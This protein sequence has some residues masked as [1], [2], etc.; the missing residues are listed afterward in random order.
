MFT[1]EN[2]MDI[3]DVPP[4]LSNLTYI[5]EQLIAQTHPVISVY[6]LKYGQMG[7]KGNVI[8]FPQ[9]VTTF[10]TQL[11][12]TIDNISRFVIVRKEGT[13]GYTDFFVNRRR[14]KLALEWLK[15]NNIW[16]GNIVISLRNLYDLPKNGD[17]LQ[18]I[19][20]SQQRR[21][22]RH[23]LNQTP[24]PRP[25]QQVTQEVQLNEENELNEEDI[26][27]TSGAPN[28]AIRNN[29]ELINLA[30]N[31]ND[32]QEHHAIINWPQVGPQPINEFTSSGYIA[33]AFPT[34]FPYGR[35]DLRNLP[36]MSISANKYFKHLM[37]YKDGRF[38]KHPRFRFFALNSFMRW[39][40][41]KNGTICISRN[42]QMNRI[43]SIR[44]LKDKLKDHPNLY[45]NILAFNSNLRSTSAYWYVR[46]REL[47]DLV[48]QIGPPTTFITLMRLIYI[49]LAL[50]S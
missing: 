3:G 1:P 24:T 18:M 23:S 44:E 34:L 47:I 21:T 28:I 30:L 25:Q 33:R 2:Q 22:Q 41:L 7:Y 36:I 50:Q 37:K 48:E 31:M 45:K 8:N 46:S 13:V 15:E 5:E 4:Q 20:D 42:E 16:Y 6:R 35:G 40:A 29:R 10:A 17:V 14:V 19:E 27:Y 11:P 9:D 43:H 49:G 26:I 38:A 12:H 39:T 32:E